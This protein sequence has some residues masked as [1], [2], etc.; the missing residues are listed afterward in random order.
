MPASTVPGDPAHWYLAYL[1]GNQGPQLPRAAR[2]PAPHGALIKG[3]GLWKYE[4]VVLR[5]CMGPTWDLIYER[6]K[7]ALVRW[8]ELGD[9]EGRLTVTQTSCLPSCGHL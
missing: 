8:G 1:Q 7:G 5:P 6:A 3:R 9:Q 4:R 2:V